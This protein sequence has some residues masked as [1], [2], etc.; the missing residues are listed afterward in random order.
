MT[1][2]EIENKLRPILTKRLTVVRGRGARMSRVMAPDF[3]SVLRSYGCGAWPS[4]WREVAFVKPQNGPGISFCVP[5]CILGY[6]VVE[7][8][9]ELAMKILVLGEMP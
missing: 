1:D 4:R 9:R 8:P 2:E 7:V 6:I 5:V 3:H